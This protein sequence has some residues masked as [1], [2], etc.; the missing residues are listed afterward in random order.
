MLDGRLVSIKRMSAQTIE[1]SI[2][3]LFAGDTDP[4]N[5]CIPVDAVLRD[6][7]SVGWLHCVSPFLRPFDDPAFEY[8]G[9]VVDCVDQLLEVSVCAIPDADGR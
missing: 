9:E 8:V 6:E 1:A 5:H 4:R 2:L 3:Q 7:D